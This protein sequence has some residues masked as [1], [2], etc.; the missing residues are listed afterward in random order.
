MPVQTVQLKI[1]NQILVDQNP[2]KQIRSLKVEV[3]NF[4]H[5]T[6]VSHIYKIACCQFQANFKWGVR[7]RVGAHY[8]R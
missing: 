7:H 6:N 3:Q 2:L 4:E 1:D 5:S 8:G